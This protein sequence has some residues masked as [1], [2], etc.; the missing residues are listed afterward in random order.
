MVVDDQKDIVTVT[1]EGLE[2]RGFAVDGF[3]DPQAAL[4][5]FK[6][7]YYD[8]VITDIKMPKI[9]G[10]DLYRELKKKDEKIKIAFLTALEIYESEFNKVFKN[11]PTTLIIKKPIRVSELAE[12]VK[13]LVKSKVN[14]S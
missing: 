8:L 2:L 9:D 10:F 5:Y 14:S 13:V 1:K 7:D 12:K 3:S 4:E 6:A 11:T